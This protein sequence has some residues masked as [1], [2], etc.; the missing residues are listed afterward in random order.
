[1]NSLVSY[2][3]GYPKDKYT[4]TFDTQYKTSG[5]ISQPEYTLNES[6]TRVGK[7]KVDRV[8]LKCSYFAFN[9]GNNILGSNINGGTITIT[10]GTYTPTTLAAA[11]QTAIRATGGGFAA[12]TVTYSSITY[13]YTISSGSV[14]TFT[15]DASGE[16]AKILGFTSNKTTVTS[17]TSDVSAYEQNIVLVASNQTFSV[18]SGVTTYNHTITAGNYNGITLAAHLQAIMIA[19][20]AGYTV[21]YN[22]YNYT[23]TITH[24][25]TAFTVNGSTSAAGVALG[26][27]TNVSST[28][29]SASSTQPIQIIGPT[30]FIIKSRAISQVRQTIVR[31]NTIYTDSIYELSLNGNLGDII[32]DNPDDG[33]ELFLSTI[34]GVTF[35]TIDFRLLDDTGKI[36]DLG[37]TGRWKIYLIFE[38]Y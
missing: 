14:S 12:A 37:T 19:Q 34:G 26:F 23:F 30:S 21:V 3:N 15:I 7:I 6:I 35:S 36:V 11:L 18:T 28:S 25:S 33:N 16:L 10:A 13:K 17:A 22:S 2:R 1:M 29:L 4:I 27:P 31:P 38:M 5:S 32:Y 9:S 24:S 20:L 8:E